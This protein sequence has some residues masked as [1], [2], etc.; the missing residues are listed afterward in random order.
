VRLLGDPDDEVRVA[1]LR[2]LGALGV[3]SAILEVA[4]RLRDSEP[5]VRLQALRELRRLSPYPEGLSLALE[6][7]LRDREPR[8]R[9]AAAAVLAGLPGRN[10]E[11]AAETLQEVLGDPEGSQR[12]FV[13]EACAEWGC[14][15]VAPALERCLQDKSASLRQAALAA[16]VRSNPTGA[17]RALIGALGDEDPTVAGD[18]AR[19]LGS[20]DGEAVTPVLT[21]LDTPE[22]EDGALRALAAIAS[23]PRAVPAEP[24]RRYGQA[25]LEA[26]HRDLQLLQVCRQLRPKRGPLIASALEESRHRE[27]IRGLRAAGLISDPQATGLALDSLGSPDGEQRANAV[28]TLDS[29][30]DPELVQPF[31]RVLETADQ[32][33]SDP[34]MVSPMSEADWLQGLAEHP[35]TWVRACAALALP[36]DPR[37][38]DADRLFRRDS[39]PLVQEAACRWGEA[40]EAVPAAAKSS[41]HRSKTDGR[42]ATAS[43]SRLPPPA[44]DGGREMK[45]LT[46]MTAVER[47]VI[48]K[49]M[50]LFAQMQLPELKRIAAVCNEQTFFDGETLGHEGE[51]GE[52]MF[53][54][55]SGAV[56]IL[57]A[58]PESRLVELARREP[59]EY[60]GEMAILS[61]EP[62]MATM[63]AAGEVRVLSI[64]RPEFEQILRHRPEA[65]MA[66]M[67]VLCARLREAESAH[68]RE[69][70]VGTKKRTPG[71]GSPAPD[72]RDEVVS[73]RSRPRPFRRARR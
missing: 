22:L 46:T 54:I 73:P 56:R 32:E 6:A 44:T 3:T 18:A 16:L 36:G 31:L 26:V 63:I 66:V 72:G 69:G 59:Y 28:E 67:R 4:G 9:S 42:K 27:T 58:G 12:L 48:L 39:D 37:F 49:Q 55:L 23:A 5:E 15:S 51:I 53:I 50:P 1:A 71:V 30:K 8:V 14:P 65:G 34:G 25:K 33:K 38:A 7:L 61:R 29:L 64:G 24:L 60:V 45:M 35:D 68:S 43:A 2:S 10:G 20:L 62:R 40:A 41:G 47:I 52:E 19:H 11:L 70:A 57:V 17:V 21:A 13:L